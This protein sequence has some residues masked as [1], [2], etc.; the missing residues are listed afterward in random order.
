MIVI[1]YISLVKLETHIMF[2]EISCSSSSVQFRKF[3][4]E[5]TSHWS[6][7]ESMFIVESKL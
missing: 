2:N 6:W 7:V 3:S 1:V 5:F 4:S